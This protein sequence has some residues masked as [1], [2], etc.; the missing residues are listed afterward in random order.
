MPSSDTN[1]SRDLTRGEQDILR[2]QFWDDHKNVEELSGLALRREPGNNRWWWDVG[3]TTLAAIDKLPDE[4]E[5]IPVYL[6][7]QGYGRTLELRPEDWVEQRQEQLEKAGQVL[8]DNVQA[9]RVVAGDLQAA[10]NLIA[11]YQ[12]VISRLVA[13][14]PNIN[15][16]NPLLLKYGVT[17]GERNAAF[18]VLLDG[19]DITDITELAESESIFD[20][21]IFDVDGDA[22][23]IHELDSGD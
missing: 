15:E 3:V 13:P 17:P 5:E 21:P 2:R 18:A 19:L 10:L 23:E 8:I 12:N 4:Y 14:D 20:H 9:V 22:E 7:V 16:A 6:H 11:D 1:Q